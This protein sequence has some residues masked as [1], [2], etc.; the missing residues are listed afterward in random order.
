MQLMQRALA[1][2]LIGGTLYAQA[3][4][5]VADSCAG[6][7]AGTVGGQAITMGDIQRYWQSHDVASFARVQQQLYEGNS[8]ALEGL[9]SE[10]LL[11]QEA[12]RRRRT[13]EQL[14]ADLSL[15]IAP[16][17][18]Q[19]IRE[20]YEKSAA[21]KQGLTLE[22]ASETID[23]YLRRQKTVRVKEDLVDG[24]KKTTPIEVRL[25]FDPPRQA[26]ESSTADPVAGQR[27]AAVEIV[28]FS[29]F[30]CPYCRQASPVL[31][32]V[33]A[34]YGDRVKLIWKDF[35]LPIHASAARAAEAAQ[36]AHEQGKFW[37]YHDLLFSNQHALAVSDL[38]KYASDI[39]LDSKAF[40]SCFSSGKYRGR[41]ASG[42]QQGRNKGVAATPTVFINGR[43]VAGAV[44]FET[45]DKVVA[46]ELGANAN[47]VGGLCP[48]PARRNDR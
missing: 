34:K 17:T 48:N 12:A 32:Q 45:Y 25:R 3:T 46:E 29:D 28:E 38:R 6:Q 41:I 36:C 33:V 4:S 8:S 27:E 30:E 2:L 7:M 31:K 39:A 26:I 37:Q 40:D 10:M 42:I 15:S 13:T 43:I 5:P 14:L 1:S 47:C 35:P 22:Q 44:P 9:I 20:T 23:A 19:E 11:A 21:S 16:P 18:D 24:L